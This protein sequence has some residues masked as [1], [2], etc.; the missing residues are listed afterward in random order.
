MSKTGTGMGRLITIH[1]EGYEP[2]EVRLHKKSPS[3]ATDELGNQFYQVY[4]STLKGRPGGGVLTWVDQ[5][6]WNQ[7]T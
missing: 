7:L 3:Q 5:D 6:T 2:G 1:P 4:K